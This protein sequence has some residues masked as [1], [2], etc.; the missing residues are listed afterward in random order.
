MNFNDEPRNEVCSLFEDYYLRARLWCLCVRACARVYVRVC[1]RAHVCVWV[2]EW[3]TKCVRYSL[4]QKVITFI[5][6]QTRL[7]T[8][9]PLI[10]HAMTDFHLNSQREFDTNKNNE[11]S[12][13]LYFS[14]CG[15]VI[16][17]KMRCSK[18]QYERDLLCLV[19]NV[20]TLET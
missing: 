16:V 12:P 1:A 13:N 7:V 8:T 14:P 18:F 11:K 19:R 9:E 2:S 17:A 4:T 6:R 15:R 3:R 20:T 10:S 5:I